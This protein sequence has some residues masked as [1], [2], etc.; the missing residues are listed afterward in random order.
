MQEALPPFT[1]PAQIK[2]N[3]LEKALLLALLPG[4]PG[5]ETQSAPTERK[6]D[7][8][9]V[10]GLLVGPQPRQTTEEEPGGQ[11][12]DAALGGGRRKPLA[13]PRPEHTHK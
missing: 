6:P 8:L 2:K 10:L 12:R 5:A 11:R 7:I 9:W 1:T 4:T 13:G 3:A